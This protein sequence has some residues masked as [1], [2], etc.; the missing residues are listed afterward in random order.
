MVRLRWDGAVGGGGL[1]VQLEDSRVGGLQGI[2]LAGGAALHHGNQSSMN[3][4]PTP[5]TPTP[6]PTLHTPYRR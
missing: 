2:G 1:V 6:H 4:H 5:H 3:S